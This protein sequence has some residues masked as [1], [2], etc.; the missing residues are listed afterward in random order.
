LSGAIEGIDDD[1][2]TVSTSQGPL[3]A[4]IGEDTAIQMFVQGTLADLHTG[5]T[6]TVIGQPGEDGTVEA[7][8]VVIIPEGG[9]GFFGG[10]RPGGDRFQRGQQ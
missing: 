10:G 7:Q 3:Q 4:T 1:T 5:L 8:S 9:A 6:V 2:V